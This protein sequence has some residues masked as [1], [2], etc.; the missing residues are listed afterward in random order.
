M[1]GRIAGALIDLSDNANEAPWDR[2][3]EAEAYGAE[4]EEIYAT[5]IIQVSDTLSEYFIA[6]RPGEG[7]TG[8]LA[9]AAIFANTIDYTHRDPLTNN[10]EL[11]RPTLSVA[12]S[13]TTTPTTPPPATGAVSRS[14]APT[15]TTCVC[16]TTRRCRVLLGSS[17]A[18]SSTIDYVLVDSNR[19]ALGDY[20]PRA[21]LWSGSGQYSIGL[22]GELL[23]LGRRRQQHQLRL[24]RHHRGPRRL[25]GQRDPGVHPGGAWRRPRPRRA[26]ARLRPRHRVD[27]RPGTLQRG[28]RE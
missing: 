20:F 25:R 27:L 5:N 15:T 19:R 11:T 4:Y 22:S 10:A 8:Y 12:P 21:Q 7:D 2:Y 26:A 6:D 24:R 17:S 14:A 18:G 23:H 1:E 3:G 13:R 28:G 16:T 9:R